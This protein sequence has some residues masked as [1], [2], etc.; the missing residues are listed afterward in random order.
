M[1]QTA[2]PDRGRRAP[3][4]TRKR[5][6]AVLEVAFLL[7][8]LCFCFVGAFDLG[9]YSYAL[10]SAEN[11]ARVVG[12]YASSSSSVAQ[13]P[14]LACSYALAELKDSP[15]VGSTSSCSSGGVV[16][17]TTSYLASGADGLPAAQVS[18]TYKPTQVVTLP[19]LINGGLTIT[20]TV[21]FPIRGS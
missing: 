11:A 19:G 14:T 18:V 8:W 16:N 4:H 5:G 6:Q 7:P 1:L 15:G 20:R 9:I 12:M 21:E 2:S 17:V 3:E 10:I 13:N